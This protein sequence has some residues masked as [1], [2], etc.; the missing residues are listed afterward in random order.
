MKVI[1]IRDPGPSVESVIEGIQEQKNLRSVMAVTIDEE[2]NLDIWCS[3]RGEDSATAAL[4]M[5]EYALAV[6]RGDVVY[7]SDSGPKE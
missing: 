2:G 3:G 4:M 7:A 6:L 1:P 5:H